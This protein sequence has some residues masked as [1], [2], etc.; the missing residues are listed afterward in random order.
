VFRLLGVHFGP[1]ISAPAAASLAGI[2]AQDARRVLHELTEAHVL[3]EHVPGRF[4]FHD[5]L[6]AYA[7]E[8]AGA[9]ADDA[10]QRAAL[11]R[12][13]DHYLHTCRSAAFLTYP[14]RDPIPLADPEP[15]V[16]PEDLH[17]RRRAMAWLQAERPV[18]LAAI[19]AAGGAG[20]DT[21]AWQIPWTMAAFL[22]LQGY[23]HDFA[24]SQQTAIAAA[25]RLGDTSALARAH[26]NLAAARARLGSYDDAGQHHEQALNLYRSLGDDLGQARVH[27]DMSWVLE[28]RGN[29]HDA[30]VHA[31]QALAMF[32]AAGHAAG[33]ARALN[34]VGWFHAVGGDLQR[35]LAYC[36]RSLDLCRQLGIGHIES[37]ALDS[38][39]D[40]HHRI[41]DYAQAISCCLQALQL[42]RELG[43][44][45]GQADTLIHLG[46]SQE[47]AGD[48]RGARQARQDA[49]ALLE[50]FHDPRVAQIR[51]KLRPLGAESSLASDESSIE[52]DRMS[53]AR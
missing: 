12:V 35:A 30:I 45:S 21:H 19:A 3:R 23:W 17:D 1:D 20:F 44:R 2:C 26:R 37:D 13:L 38:L 4:A 41:G 16:L 29:C 36:E 22:D 50:G 9:R 11:R 43:D 40:I 34:L 6:R 33:E 51:V 7:A 46:D 10:E 42:R 27:S 18:L 14:G 24:V 5:L 48:Q 49:L 8:L 28:L 25:R 53:R 39:G 15:T 31:K 47:A 32:Q 52:L